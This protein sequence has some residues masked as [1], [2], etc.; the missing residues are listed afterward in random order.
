MSKK[1]EQFFATCPRGLEALLGEELRELGA[2]AI[3]PTYGGVAFSGEYELCYRANLHSRLASRVL[4]RVGGGEYRDEED[5]YHGALSFDWPTMFSVD[6]TIVVKMTAQKAPLK[7]LEF[8][9]LRIKDAICDRF[10]EATGERP[11]V[12]IREPDVRIHVFLTATECT[13]YLDTSGQSLF[14]RGLRKQAGAA[15]L[16]ENLAAGMVKLS[17]W[18]PGTPFFDPMCGSA[19]ILMEAA[20]V[21]LNIAPGSHRDFGFEKLTRFDPKVWLPI[22]QAA[23]DAQLPATLQPIFGRDMFGDS[24]RDAQVNLEAAGLA[25]VIQLKQGNV[26]EVPAPADHGVIVTNPPYGIRIGEQS[27]LAEFYPQLGNWLKQK[28]TGWNAYILSADMNLPKL[29]RLNATKR[30]PLFNGALECRLFEYKIV[31]G[32]ARK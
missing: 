1:L 27:E 11:N 6:K 24:L 31:A 18:Q 20:Q 17:G 2:Q 32:S 5:I 15:P 19:T 23:I 10:R 8:T 25:G 30:T 13:L 9:T 4:L 7:S 21:A 29:I 26:I 12:D 28:C 16:N 22:K 3:A 14:K